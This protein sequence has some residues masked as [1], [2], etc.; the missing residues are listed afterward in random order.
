[1]KPADLAIDPQDPAAGLF[2]SQGASSVAFLD[3]SVRA[4]AQAIDKRM[5]MHLFM[6]ADGNVV[7]ID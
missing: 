6:H 7:N 1:M 5:W 4:V 3:G 2:F